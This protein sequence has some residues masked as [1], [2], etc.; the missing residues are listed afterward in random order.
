MTWLMLVSIPS[1]HDFKVSGFPAHLGSRLVIPFRITTKSFISVYNPHHPL[2]DPFWVIITSHVIIGATLARLHCFWLKEK[3][4]FTRLTCSLS[5]E[6][7]NV[8]LS[9]EPLAL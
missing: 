3:Q 7:P 8:P 2:E 1:I 4:S 9:S 6:N 5:L